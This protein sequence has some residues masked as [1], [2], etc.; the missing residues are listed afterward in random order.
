MQPGP[1]DPGPYGS[2]PGPQVEVLSRPEGPRS[3]REP[4][5][6]SRRFKV[7][8]AVFLLVL[9]A[10][11]I[12][13][14]TRPAIY[15]ATATVLVE[16]PEGIGFGAGENGADLQN[17][18]AQGRVLMARD[19]LEETLERA[20]RQGGSVSA[21]DPDALRAMLEVRP[22]PETNLVELA[23]IG[24]DPDQL[25]TLVN[26][27]V[28]AYLGRRQQQVETDVDETLGRLQEEYERLDAEK[29]EK[30]AALDGYR[31]ANAIDTMEQEGN[32][33]LA[34]LKSLTEELNL[35]RGEHV[36][37]QAELEAL[38]QA[39]A[40]G[41]PV[42]PPAEQ[43]GLDELLREQ[44]Q[45]STRLTEL[46]KRYTKLY[47]EHEPTLREIPDALEQVNS[48]IE[49]KLAAGRDYMRSHA[50]RDV[51][52]TRRQ[53]EVMEQQLAVAR[54]EASRFTQ[55]YARYE[56]LKAD[57]EG[58]DELHREL[59]AR[60]MDV[61][62]KAPQ[63]YKQVEV[64]EPAFPPRI[65]FQPDYW[66]DFTY[67]LGAAAL[68]ALLA[69]LLLE[70]L[71]RRE[72]DE[73]EML[74]VTG[75]RVFAPPGGDAPLGHPAQATALGAVRPGAIPRDEMPALP[76]AIRRELLAA[77]VRALTELA[78]PASRQLI[79]LIM[80]GLTPAECVALEESHI[81]LGL[82]VLHAP[83]DGR[84]IPLGSGLRAELAGHRPLP[85][86]LGAAGGADLDA[87][88]GRIAL[89]AHDA[90]LSQPGEVDVA[91]LRHT[92]ICYLV[93]QG[94]RLTEIERVIGPVPA[95]ELGRYSAY[96]PKGA[97][98]PLTQVELTYPAFESRP[99]PKI[100]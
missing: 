7:F 23:A 95:A 37:A 2:A 31:Q 88:L 51:S 28:D 75:V 40:R 21:L 10:G 33:A 26:A 59:E 49:S 64:L 53:V 47:M 66:R 79:G 55:K 78:D 81:D 18:T 38:E 86:W 58:V 35:A 3:V 74:P 16:A 63:R 67:N 8:A 24:A 45:L 61:K 52:R 96:S 13:N 97:A 5:R 41:E 98:K 73:S 90:G 32:Q 84:E 83:G 76:G 48:L 71:T 87:L 20:A 82:G 19:L 50:A 56:R 46:E 15:R 62:A 30:A 54:S 89:L 36:K 17:V 25:A 22:A 85:L 70:F 12:W 27:W 92:Y 9:A 77:E 72:R 100:S 1:H 99:G 6:S 68:T 80:I 34:R 93:R 39:I 94:A 57:L 65:P 42:V 69:V 60:L 4:L 44:A 11:S 43:E 14:F 29:R 91:A